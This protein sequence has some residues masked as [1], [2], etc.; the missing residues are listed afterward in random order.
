M[1]VALGDM[2]ESPRELPQELP[3]C[4]ELAWWVTSWL[5]GLTGGDDLIDRYGA[6]LD[7]LGRLRGAAA[8]AALEHG[9]PGAGV[10]LPVPGDLSGLAGPREFN[11]AALDAGQ[12]L[13]VGA[14]GL[15]P[16]E[17]GWCSHTA[18]RRPPPDLGEARRDLRTAMVHAT[19]ALSRLDIAR[20]RPDLAASVAGLRRP[21]TPQAPAG[22]PP[23]AAELAARG[24]RA[25]A[26]VELAATDLDGVADH[27]RA[28]SAHEIGARAG[29]LRDLDR[30]ARRAVVAACSADAW[31]PHG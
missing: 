22:T 13:L 7:L 20:W 8:D 9:A 15:V 31:P 6:D 16:T 10:A 27:G 18:D 29:V 12:A 5:R 11:A 23:E 24:A 4:A 25:L 26:I 21:A 14:L 19:D 17:Q 30:A 3:Q 28:L 1:P 2:S